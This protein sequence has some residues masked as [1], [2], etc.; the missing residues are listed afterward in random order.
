VF[1]VLR[2]YSVALD[3]GAIVIVKDG[4]CRLRH[5]PIRR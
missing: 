5:L 3:A 4:G 2:A 1:Q